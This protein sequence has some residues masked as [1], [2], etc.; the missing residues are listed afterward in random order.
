MTRR[1]LGSGTSEDHP[2][3]VYELF[4]RSTFAAKTKVTHPSRYSILQ[5][6]RLILCIE[7]DRVQK[8]FDFFEIE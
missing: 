5:R 7:V 8:S 3:T 4:Q 2:H 6:T 1:V